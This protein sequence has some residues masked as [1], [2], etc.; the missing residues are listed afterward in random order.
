MSYSGDLRGKI[1]TQDNSI[2]FQMRVKKNQERIDETTDTSFVLVSA[3]LASTEA[4]SSGTNMRLESIE[5]RVYLSRPQAM[6]PALDHEQESGDCSRR[7]Q[8][9]C[10]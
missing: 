10:Y 9:A 1:I 2:C 6:F 3:T 4:E 8:E 7:P 5:T